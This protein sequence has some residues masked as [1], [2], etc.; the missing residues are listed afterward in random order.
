MIGPKN[1][2]PD[3]SPL[4]DEMPASARPPGR[5]ASPP[6][7]RWGR[8]GLLAVF[9]CSFPVAAQAKPAD[10]KKGLALA[11]S[12]DCVAAVPLLERAE[13]DGHR[14]ATAAALARCHVSLGEVFLGWEIFDALA[15][16]K[17]TREWTADDRAAKASASKQAEELDRRLPRLTL[18]IKPQDA[19]VDVLVAGRPV[20]DL[21]EPVRAPPDEKI[22]I[23]V[24]GEGFE[25]FRQSI[26]LT[27]GQKKTISVELQREA[28]DSGG[29]GT[30]KPEG[31]SKKPTSPAPTGPKYWMGARFRGLLVPTF[32]MNIVAD[33]GT[34]TYWPGGG[35]TFGARVGDVDLVTSVSVTSYALSTTPF[36]PHD[37]PDTEW[38]LVESDL[39]GLAASLDVLYVIPL[40]PKEEGAIKIGAGFGLGWAFAGDLY[41]WQSYPKDGKEGD[42]ATY[43]KCAGPNNPAGTFRY[44]NQLDK[45]AERYGSADKTWS[46]GGARP[47]VYPWLALPLIDFAYRPIDDLGLDLEVGLTLNGFL[48]GVGARY[49]F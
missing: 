3:S 24:S 13:A 15:R 30:P 41:R 26:V 18:R 2:L 23:R 4:G 29:D 28:G 14:P 39:V 11:K 16:E 7:R 22:E 49:G 5:P 6:S 17:P 37:T 9:L 25:E 36:K 34:T 42:P 1:L 31:P 48:T 19:V 45:D 38:E 47:V 10:A 8:V 46:D 33:G 27:E 32:V 40:D 43:Q 35:L 44:C 21:S 20:E 12:G